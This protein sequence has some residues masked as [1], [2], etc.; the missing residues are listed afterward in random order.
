MAQISPLIQ[1]KI[2]KILMIPE[3]SIER[4][5][6]KPLNSRREE[7]LCVE[8]LESQRLSEVS[9]LNTNISTRRSVEGEV[10]SY[11][12][13]CCAR[14][15]TCDRFNFHLLHTFFEERFPA[16]AVSILDF[17]FY[18][19]KS[20]CIL[21]FVCNKKNKIY[22]LQSFDENQ[23]SNYRLHYLMLF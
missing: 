13:L 20:K 7:K 23:A 15:Q 14:L 8:F 10:I 18:F 6:F 2:A 3:E 21:Y 17:P 9:Y 4:I 11:I 5:N 16:F 12:L 19:V 22:A 1:T